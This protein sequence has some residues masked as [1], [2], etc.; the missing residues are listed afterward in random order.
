MNDVA[1]RLPEEELRQLVKVIQDGGGVDYSPKRGGVCPVCE[2]EKCRVT[3]TSPW[4]GSVR[5]RFHR[6][7][8]CGLRFKSVE[9]E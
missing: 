8:V 1:K 6:C 5:E 2:T 9:V 4:T 3:N 7:R